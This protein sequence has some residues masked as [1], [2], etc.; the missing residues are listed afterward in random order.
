MQKHG[1]VFS[2]QKQQPRSEYQLQVAILCTL[3]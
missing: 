1:L 3:F 2:Q